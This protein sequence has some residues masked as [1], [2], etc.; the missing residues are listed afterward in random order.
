MVNNRKRAENQENYGTFLRKIG[1]IP[2]VIKICAYVI[3]TEAPVL[4][5]ARKHWGVV[6]KSVQ[7][8]FST[9][10]STSLRAGSLGSLEMTRISTLIIRN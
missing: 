9:R 5:F 7:I 4:A 2:I 10:P 8:D 3:S 6:E 1:V